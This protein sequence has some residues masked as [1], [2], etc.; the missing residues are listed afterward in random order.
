MDFQFVDCDEFNLSADDVNRIL[1]ETDW[2]AFEKW[3]EEK[4][5]P[6]GLQL[7]EL[8]FHVTIREYIEKIGKEAGLSKEELADTTLL[9]KMCLMVDSM[10]S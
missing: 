8:H 1:K 5:L 9:M 6:M 2:D 3:W 7:V 10:I 4:K